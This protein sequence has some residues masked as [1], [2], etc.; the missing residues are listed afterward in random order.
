MFVLNPNW[1]TDI[2]KM[3]IKNPKDLESFLRQKKQKLIPLT[4]KEIDRIEEKYN[5]KL[6]DYYIQF[7]LKMGKSADKYMLGSSAF[8]DEI[9]I[10]NDEAPSLL[11]EN[12]INNP[13]PKNSF[14][15]WMHQGYQMA[16]FV[17]DKSINPEV[18]YFTEV[19]PEKGFV[20]VGT[21]MDFFKI[22]LQH[23]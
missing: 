18:F 11:K 21:L 23:I 22:H 17:C 10:I 1:H 3:E 7:L 2:I 16:F 4:E 19:E 12:N 13:L 8:Y 5:L 9:D 14:V 15:F 6:P 20:N